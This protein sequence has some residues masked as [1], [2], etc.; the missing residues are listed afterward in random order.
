MRVSKKIIILFV[1]LLFLPMPALASE[2]LENETP[3]KKVGP[4]INNYEKIDINTL[5]LIDKSEMVTEIFDNYGDMI[6]YFKKDHRWEAKVWSWHKK[7][8]SWIPRYSN[9]DNPTI[10]CISN[11]RKV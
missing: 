9:W 2:K 1:G 8:W 5:K 10:V 7:K 4:A 3:T 6:K 11:E